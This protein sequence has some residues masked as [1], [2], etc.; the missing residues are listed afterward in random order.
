MD[1]RINEH[2]FTSSFERTRAFLH[3]KGILIKL[4][5]FATDKKYLPDSDPDF[6][7][8]NGITGEF[9]RACMEMQ[10]NKTPTRSDLMNAV[11]GKVN[12]Q[13]KVPLKNTVQTLI[14]SDT[15]ELCLF[16]ADILPHLSL[17]S[18]NPKLRAIQ[19]FIVNLLID[20][21]VK[22]II[23]NSKGKK[24]ENILYN[25]VIERLD[26]LSEKTERDDEY[27]GYY[28]GALAIRIRTL[29]KEDLKN[30]SQLEEFYVA[31]VSHLIK[32]YYFHYIT[33]LSLRLADFFDTSREMHPVFFTLTWEKLSRS[34]LALEHGWKKLETSATTLFAHANTLEL[35]NTIDF[36][37]AFLHI[38]APFTYREITI[39]VG[40]MTEDEE[41]NFAF[42]VN[43]LITRYQSKLDFKWEVFDD[44]YVMPDDEIYQKYHSLNL[45]HRLYSM[46]K[47]QF[48]NS[49]RSGAYADFSVWYKAFVKANYFKLRGNLGGSLKIDRDLLLLIT[50][51]A[52]MSTGNDKILVNA[53]WTA[54]EKRGIFLDEKSRREIF[55][56]FEKSNILEKKSDSGDAQYVKR[57]Y[58]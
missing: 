24:H 17:K 57:L 54:F 9:F 39:A 6:K 22:A 56:F 37:K 33:Q 20:D 40:T 8:F 47:Y 44:S 25:L 27:T 48:E 7:S 12:T 32:Y 35:L 16:N 21:D 30:L 53:L 2:N 43:Q 55:T 13:H 4:F 49:G 38:Q 19:E 58:K 36:G 26:A 18:D 41:K 42:V 45:I 10:F 11:V 29:F 52:I 51:L 34:R 28:Q 14:Y 1:F 31:N 46:V 50:E 5:P 23:K 15:D 3:N